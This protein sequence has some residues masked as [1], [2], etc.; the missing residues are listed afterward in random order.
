MKQEMFKKVQADRQLRARHLHV[1]S[2]SWHTLH[3]LEVAT[4][5]TETVSISHLLYGVH[6]SGDNFLSLSLISQS[7][8]LFS[9]SSVIIFSLFVICISN[10]AA[11]FSLSIILCLVSITY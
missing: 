8:S 11:D 7:I 9:D 2:F 5:G 4:S 1:P 10:L 6:G 3:C